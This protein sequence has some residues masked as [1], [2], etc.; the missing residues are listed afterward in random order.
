MS[1]W[2]RESK[3][4]RIKR[5]KNAYS[6]EFLNFMISFPYFS[7]SSWVCFFTLWSKWNSNERPKFRRSLMY[8]RLKWLFLPLFTHKLPESFSYNFVFL[9][10][11][12]FILRVDNILLVLGM[13]WNINSSSNTQRHRNVSLTS[14]DLPYFIEVDRHIDIFYNR[15][16]VL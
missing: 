9:R 10:L 6:E 2:V 7:F 4:D 5:I 13:S 11:C 15:F 16:I 8:I 3:I 1:K 14:I 12:F